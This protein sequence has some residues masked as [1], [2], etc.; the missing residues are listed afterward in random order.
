MDKTS[1]ELFEILRDE[2]PRICIVLL[3]QTDKGE[4]VMH[5]DS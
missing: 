1:W 5:A 4:I 3:Q 2:M